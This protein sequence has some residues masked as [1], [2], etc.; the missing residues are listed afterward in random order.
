MRRTSSI[1]G[2]GLLGLALMPASAQAVV[3]RF[4]AVTANNLA[5]VAIGEAQMGVEVTEDSLDPELIN[6]RFFNDGPE[7]SSITD[8]YFDDNAGVLFDGGI[9]RLV[10]SDGTGTDGNLGDPG[11][12][13]SIGA[14]PPDLPGAPGDFSPNNSDFTAD[15]DSS[16]GGV[17][18]NGVN[19]GEELIV[20]FALLVG[21]LKTFDDLL[22]ALEAGSDGLRIG[23]HVQGFDGG[24]SESFINLPPSVVPPG[25][26]SEPAAL[27]LIGT[28][29]LGLGWRRRAHR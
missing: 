26:V 16:G 14:S 8:V 20:Q 28:G 13:F 17:F 19:P 23:I 12:D 21:D 15:S 4:E 9:T 22:A 11:V 2:L 29:L 5:D 27:L 7:P 3:L 24:G 6:F 25:E 1:I 18:A 10:D